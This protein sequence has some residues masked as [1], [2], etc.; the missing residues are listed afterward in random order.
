SYLSEDK[1]AETLLKDFIQHSYDAENIQQ[2]RLLLGNIY[3]AKNDYKKAEAEYEKINPKELIRSN[4]EE[5]LLNSGLIKFKE[6]DYD[7]A[8]PLFSSL[9]SESIIYRND[10]IFYKACIDYER[11]N[12]VDAEKGFKII[13]H[14]K[15]YGLTSQYYLIGI[16]FAGKRYSQS[17]SSGENLLSARYGNEQETSEIMRICGVSEFMGGNRKKCIY[18]LE[19]YSNSPSV[20]IDN[21]ALYL[22]GISYYMDKQYTDAIKT[23]GEVAGNDE[24]LTQSAHIYLGHSYIAIGDKDG[25][26][27]AYERAAE[28]DADMQA[29]ETALYNYALLLNET[30]LVSFEKSVQTFENYLNLFADSKNASAINELLV[31][32]YFTTHNYDAALVSINNI[33]RPGATILK[34]KQAI[35]YRMG[36]EA[37][38]NSRDEEAYNLFTQAINMGNY[39]PGIVGKASFWRG[40]IAYRDKR[41]ADASADFSQHLKTS[42]QTD[43][44]AYY[45]L[46]YIKF[47]TLAYSDALEFF[48][49]YVKNIPENSDVKVLSDAWCRI[50]DCRYMAKN[51]TGADQAYAKAGEL[52][53]STGD[54]ALFRRGWIAG[55]QKR[56][57]DKENIMSLLVQNSPDSPYAPG[58]MLENGLALLEQGKVS[59]ATACFDKLYLKYPQSKAAKAGALQ[60][61]MAYINN[62]DTEKAIASYKKVIEVYPGSEE[63]RIAASDLKNIY[64]QHGDISSYTEYV[65]GVNVGSIKY[66]VSEMDSLT[67]LAAENSFLKLP[68][69]KSVIKFSDYIQNYPDG[70]FVSDAAFYIGRYRYDNKDFSKSRTQLEKVLSTQGSR[71]ADDALTILAAI[72]EKE[73]NHKAAQQYYRQLAVKNTSPETVKKA[74]IGELRMSVALKE[75]NNIISEA[76]ALLNGNISDETAKE[77]I[78]QRAQAYSG[79]GRW[80]EAAN[81]WEILSSDPRN[82]YGAEA[83][84]QLAQYRFNNKEIKKAEEITNSLISGSY[85]HKYWVARG[86]ILLSDISAAKGDK[87]KAKQYLKSLS[88]NYEGKDDIKKLINDRINKY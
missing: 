23:L 61:A 1:D 43:P 86:I 53:P 32:R 72:E 29:K 15:K 20:T 27:L 76:T 41:Y 24:G 38:I 40:E 28:S 69:E 85:S 16:Y 26:L 62:G 39:N 64:V 51:Y 11:N 50:G 3:L 87:F 84:Y 5:L 25:A 88:G 58:A 13:E 75:Y 6:G 22:L 60:T 46:G 66:D 77:A 74:K 70:A 8:M 34:A 80:K 81:D 35:L 18:Y 12:Y 10:G 7:E 31:D 17:L 36:S 30:S 19:Q 57:S 44:T 54:Y 52:S 73:N 83:C 63:A 67:F 65:N 21:N 71:F 55:L 33:K 56:F 47:K 59:D 45:N 82:A 49:S 78:F 4:R 42:S 48:N 68:G 9:A 37:Y 79:I 2:A 14:D